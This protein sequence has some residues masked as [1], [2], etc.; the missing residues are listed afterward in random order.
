[1]EADHHAPKLLV[2]TKLIS[3][4]TDR[5][6]AQTTIDAIVLDVQSNMEMGIFLSFFQ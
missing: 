6:M 5:H 4:C 2:Q 3:T 1:M